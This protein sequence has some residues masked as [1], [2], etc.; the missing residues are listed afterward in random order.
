[1][2]RLSMLFAL[3]L[4]GIALPFAGCNKA[5]EVADPEKSAAPAEPGKEGEVKPGAGAPA[6][7]AEPELPPQTGGG[8]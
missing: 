1:M 2:K 7:F 4:L 3:L 6:E 5:E 8:G